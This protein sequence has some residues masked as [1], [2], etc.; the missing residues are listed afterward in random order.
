MNPILTIS[1]GRGTGESTLS[2]KT[3][4]DYLDITRGLIILLVVLFHSPFSHG[5]YIGWFRMPSFFILSGL[6]YKQPAPHHVI[7]FL[8]K[9]TCNLLIPYVAYAVLL[10]AILAGKDQ[11]K[12]LT[13]FNG[14]HLFFTLFSKEFA[15]TLSLLFYG[16]DMIPGGS[17]VTFWF[18]NCL[19]LSI[20]LFTILKTLIKNQFAFLTTVSVAYL[21]GVFLCNTI[22]YPLPWGF[23]IALIALP[24]FAIGFYSKEILNNINRNLS[25]F[26]PIFFLLIGICFGLIILNK[27]GLFSFMFSFRGGLFPDP[28]LTLIIPPFY[29]LMVLMTSMLLS[30]TWLNRYLSYLGRNT[31][32][33][34]FLHMTVGMFVKMGHHYFHREPHFLVWMTISLG[35]PLI[36]ASFLDKYKFTQMLF[37]GKN[38]DQF[39]PTIKQY[40]IKQQRSSLVE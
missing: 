16:G 37:L 25:S 15:G 1:P 19:Y 31:L 34:L 18:I 4:L 2:N 6:L 36:A 27:A 7:S 12:E 22:K 33:I 32:P 11:L 24:F 40:F 5:S 13:S 8:K 21:V 3:R 17:L 28:L 14:Y 23:N 39:I 26:V 38:S 9:K 30:N 10:T 20:V 29:T 35:L